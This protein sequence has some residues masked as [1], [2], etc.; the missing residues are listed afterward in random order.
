MRVILFT[1][2][3]NRFTPILLHPILERF[4]NRI[5]AAYLSK[6]THVVSRFLLRQAWFLA[7]NLYP[8]CISPRDLI[9]YALRPRPAFQGTVLE[10]LRSRGIDAEYLTEIRSA[11]TRE[12]MAAHQPDVFLFCPFDKIAGPKFLSIPR[13]GTYN[14]HLG[15]LP[16]H[17]GGLGAFWVLRFGEPDAGAAFHRAILEVDAGEIIAE[18]RFPVTTRSM[19]QLM[20]DTVRAAGPMV[21]DGLEKLESG[22][23]SPID[24]RG[25][26]VG[27]HILP[28]R[29]DFRAFY[30]RGCRLI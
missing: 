24:I 6:E 2:E 13:L 9:R 12:R 19:E 5:I 16:E 25:R 29:E 22:H 4:G 10:F 17:R 7:K 27:Y 3:E 23:Y 1:L 21:V 18:V 8:F 26:P 30:R 15:K 28:S 20:L 14:T 11:A